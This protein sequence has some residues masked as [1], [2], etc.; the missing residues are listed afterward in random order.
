MIP[1][2]DQAVND[3]ENKWHCHHIMENSGYSL[4]WLK[5]NHL[6]YKRPYY[7]LIFLT[8]AEHNRVH[9]KGKTLKEEHKKKCSDSLRGMTKTDDWKRKIGEANKGK[10]RS[11]SFCKLMSDYAKARNYNPMKG[12]K[13]SEETRKKISEKR[14]AY[15]KKLHGE[16]ECLL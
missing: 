13:H 6:Y 3:K 12:R 8:I 4:E 15:Y 9:K 10:K 5:K 1:N 2:Y 16:F 14:I 7:E 11:E